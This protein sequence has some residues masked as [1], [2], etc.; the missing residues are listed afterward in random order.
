MTNANIEISVVDLFTEAVTGL[1]IFQTLAA[2]DIPTSTIF[3]LYTYNAQQTGGSFLECGTSLVEISESFGGNQ[4]FSC[5]IVELLEEGE[6]YA[7]IHGKQYS[8][9]DAAAYAELAMLDFVDRSIVDHDLS[10]LEYEMEFII[11]T[12]ATANESKPTKPQLDGVSHLANRLAEIQ[13]RLNIIN[14]VRLLRQLK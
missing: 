12:L 2:E 8:L 1:R 3:D 14:N 5:T 6:G 4:I 7:M 10:K 11:G 9:Q 13:S